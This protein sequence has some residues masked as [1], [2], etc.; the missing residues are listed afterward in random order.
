MASIAAAKRNLPTSLQLFW[1]SSPVSGRVDVWLS[2]AFFLIS[3]SSYYFHWF[4]L[5]P[6]LHHDATG[7]AVHARDF[8]QED[9]FPFYIFHQ[10]GPHPLIIYIQALVFSVS[11]YS[12]AGLQGVTIVGGALV[13]PAIYWASRWVFD[14]SGT[15]F[16]RRAGLIAAL[17]TALST[18]FA[19]HSYLGLEPGLLPVV[20]VTAV[21]FLWR[22]IRRG[23]MLDF[24]LAGLLIGVSQYVYVAA[25][26]FPL[27]LAVA[28]AGATLANSRLLM[29]WRHLLLAS[30]ASAIVAIPQ[31]MMFAAYPFTLFARITEAD[32][33]A[34]GQF[35]VTLPDPVAVIVAK[36]KNQ[37]EALC[38]LWQTDGPYGPRSILTA[39]LVAGLIIGIATVIR[40]RR[41]GQVFGLLMMGLMLLPDLLTFEWLDHAAVDFSRLLAGVPFI[42]IV[43][44]SGT[45]AIWA[46]IESRR[47]IPRWMGYLVP[48]L[49]LLFGLNRQWDFAQRITPY[50]LA[51]PGEGWQLGPI[52]EFIGINHDTSILLPTSQYSDSRLA[53]LL[54][55]QFPHRKGGG[56][57]TLLQGESVT[58][59]LPDSEWTIDEGFPEE[60]VLL[61]DGTVFFLPPMPE[62]VEPLNEKE[63][64]IFSRNGAAAAKAL[65]ARWQGGSPTYTPLEASAFVNDLKLVGFQSNEL[66]PGSGLDVTFF[67]QPTKKIRRDVELFVRL[68]SPKF[69]ASV[70]EVQDW[71]LNGVYR[72][73]VWQP[74]QIMPLSYSLP[75]PHIL[76]PGPYQLQVGFIDLLGR[77]RVP[78]TT[79]QDALTVKTFEIPLPEDHLAPEISADI[80]FGNTIELEGYT[81]TPATDGLKVILFWRV[82]EPTVTDYTLFVHIVGSDDEKVAQSD[83]EPF[84]GSFP[85]STWTAGELFVEERFMPAVPD[86]EYRIYVGWY[87]HREGGWER[88]STVAREGMPATDHLMLDTIILR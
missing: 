87:T 84:Y 76:P 54:T 71:P 57:E 24:V 64:T 11:G 3:L 17:G 79:G 82:I 53:F 75:L 70:A 61:K 26:F 25:R 8:L 60:W 80:N 73:R 66:E 32:R 50:R 78:L 77:H 28:F 31:W 27:A 83:R 48:A 7:L 23:H 67:W 6:P 46:W 22:G 72:V 36:L 9:I 88:L 2:V 55:E 39:V 44:G 69:K 47:R 56:E 85:T 81:L 18:F 74:G 1:K 52:A 33:T 10:H 12:V 38:F 14:Y 62:S 59:I 65:E 29:H 21:A 20:E 45:A 43:A 34:G 51:N 68:Y 40:Q 13:A 30:A 49:V 4:R 42:F 15:A 16:A 41:D 58:V 86:G 63:T 37:L 35:V 19:S 5:T